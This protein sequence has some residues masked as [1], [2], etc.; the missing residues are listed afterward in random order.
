[1]SAPPHTVVAGKG[2][3]LRSAAP[4]VAKQCHVA[5]SGPN[6]S[7]HFAVS[8]S[9]DVAHTSQVV[10]TCDPLAAGSLTTQE[11]VA[12][13]AVNGKVRT[14]SQ[15]ALATSFQ[16]AN[17]HVQQDTSAQAYLA[18]GTLFTP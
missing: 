16:H 3:V 13:L 8:N 15:P 11:G 9:A 6:A 10:G 14:G 7:G 18:A 17:L 12:Y 2:Y 5:L 4:H 1:M